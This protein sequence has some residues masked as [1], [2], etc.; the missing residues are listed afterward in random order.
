MTDEGNT[1]SLTVYLIVSHLLQISLF[2]V[3]LLKPP[4]SVCGVKVSHTCSRFSG[5]NR[6]NFQPDV[7]ESPTQM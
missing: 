2:V 6:R 1:C 7:K 4:A 5:Q 3:F